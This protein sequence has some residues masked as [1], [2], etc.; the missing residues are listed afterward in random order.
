[1]S[2]T[3]TTTSTPRSS[4]SLVNL[5]HEGS[6][7]ALD[8]IFT[9]IDSESIQSA[10]QEHNSEDEDKPAKKKKT[11]IWRYPTNTEVLVLF[12]NCL[13]SDIDQ[14]VKEANSHSEAWRS[15][16]P[17]VEA[18]VLD[19][20]LIRIYP[21]KQEKRDRE[22]RYRRELQKVKDALSLNKSKKE[23]TKEQ[24]EQMQL[25]NAD[26]E[27]K[28]QK[29]LRQNARRQLLREKK[30]KDPSK[31]NQ[32][33]VALMHKLDPSWKPINKRKKEPKEKKQTK[34]QKISDGSAKELRRTESRRDLT[35]SKNT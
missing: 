3:K 16:S 29:Q 19:N 15:L 32:K 8:Q 18:K 21:T 35:Q 25:Y 30:E 7:D 20:S 31:F 33:V 34:K 11:P 10:T 28:H 12:N 17:N 4:S 24:K 23:L 6:E 27:V 22:N 14:L 5:I 26:P 2:Q 13:L 1:M 9:Q